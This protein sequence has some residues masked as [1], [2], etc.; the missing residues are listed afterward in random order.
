MDHCVTIVV[1]DTNAHVHVMGHIALLA[2]H[3]I[4][5]SIILLPHL[6]EELLAGAQGM[7]APIGHV[8]QTGSADLHPEYRKLGEYANFHP[9]SRLTE[10]NHS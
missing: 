7:G 6:L 2:G 8:E 9:K 3:V 10:Y 1:L 5:L 4:D